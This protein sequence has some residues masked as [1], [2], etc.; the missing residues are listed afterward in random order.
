M[1]RRVVEGDPAQVL[2]EMARDGDYLVVGSGHKG[3]L[4]RGRSSDRSA[5]TASNTPT[6][7]WSSSF[8][9]PNPG[10]PEGWPPEQ[11]AVRAGRPVSAA[12]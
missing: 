6:A 5:S 2:T 3:G 8:L 10:P 1:T 11:R 7:P 4:R 9:R 12:G